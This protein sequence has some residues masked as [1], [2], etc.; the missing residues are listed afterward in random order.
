MSNYGNS[1]WILTPQ[2][3]GRPYK[4]IDLSGTDWFDFTHWS[5][6]FTYNLSIDLRPASYYNPLLNYDYGYRLQISARTII[7]NMASG[8]GNDRII[9]N[10][11][12]NKILAGD[13]HDSV[14]ALAGNDQIAGGAGN[15]RLFG[16]DGNDRIAGGAGVDAIY[17]GTGRDK[18]SG[19]THADY[20]FGGRGNDVLVGNEGQDRLYGGAGVDR[21]V[22]HEVMFKYTGDSTILNPDLNKPSFTQ[23]TETP[24]AA[25]DYIFGFDN[26]GNAPGDV[27]DLSAIDANINGHPFPTFNEGFV[28]RGT[29][30]GP[31]VRDLYLREEGT[32]TIVY[33]NTYAPYAPDFKIVIVDGATRAW[34]YTALDFV[35]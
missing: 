11:A 3:G 12:K 25:P 34:E 5:G 22:F 1:S 24:V 13:G 27:I 15:D 18:L 26:P 31:D 19:G 7:E 10:N 4:I 2:M 35:L 28:F 17:G 32:N 30:P 29:G 16:G 6:W 23:N 14:W 8:A 9:T 33:G 21:F 20:L